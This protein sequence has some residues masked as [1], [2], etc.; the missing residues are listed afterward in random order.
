[1]ALISCKECA[2]QVSD[3]ASSCPHCGAPVGVAAVSGQRFGESAQP[4]AKKSGGLWKWI[5]GVPVG[6]FVLMMFIGGMNSNP[7][8]THARRAYEACIDSLQT[9]DRARRG[10]GGFIA[11]ACEKMRDDFIQKYGS[12]P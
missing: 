1:M 6:L 2:G 4:V 7:E 3:S 8:K 5:L 12:T 9:D 11:G 10:N